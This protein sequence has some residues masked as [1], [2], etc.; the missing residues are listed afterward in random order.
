M[1][2]KEILKHCLIELTADLPENVH[3]FWRSK[4]DGQYQMERRYNLLSDKVFEA[5]FAVGDVYAVV[6]SIKAVGAL[7]DEELASLYERFDKALSEAEE[8]VWS[9]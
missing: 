8:K 4:L 7:D 5:V 6:D 3:D 9:C 1:T 2:V